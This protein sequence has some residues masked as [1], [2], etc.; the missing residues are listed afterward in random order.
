MR[1]IS[2]ILTLVLISCLA[3]SQ[4]ALATNITIIAAPSYVGFSSSP[5]A[6]TLNGIAGTGV[7]DVDTTYYANPL[8][9]ETPPTEIVVDEECYFTWD[10]TSSVNITVSVNC[11]NFTSGDADM[12]NSGDGTNGATTYGGYSYYSGG[13]TS[14][15]LETPI[16]KETGSEILYT[17]TVAGEDKKWGCW[18][19]TRTDAWTGGTPSTTTMV[20]SAIE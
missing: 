10:N 1:K 19:E 20:I 2:V 15:I 12:T 6:W 11:G 13:N 18:I 17:T 5:T 7:I 9:D 3:L 8:G 16:M 14:A 4:V